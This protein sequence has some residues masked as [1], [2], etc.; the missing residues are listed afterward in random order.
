MSD[1]DPIK[2]LKDLISLIDEAIQGIAALFF[3]TL[4]IDIIWITKVLPNR[5]EKGVLKASFELGHYL[6]FIIF[7]LCG[8]AIIIYILKHLKKEL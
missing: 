7:L 4:V 3:S 2:N 6:L 5:E 1:E 8:I